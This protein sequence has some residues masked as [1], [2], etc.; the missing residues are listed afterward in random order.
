MTKRALPLVALYLAMAASTRI[1]EPAYFGYIIAFGVFIAGYGTQLL[2]RKNAPPLSGPVLLGWAVFAALVLLTTLLAKPAFRDLFRDCGAI[3]SFL[4]GLVV[5]PRALGKDWERPLFAGLSA[6][7]MVIS[8]WTILGAVAAYLAGAG[9]YEWRGVYVPFAHGWLP[10][11]IVAEYIRSRS[12]ADFRVSAF[13]IGLCVLALL[14]SLSRTGILLV[15][16]FGV[17]ILL[18]NARHWLLSARGMAMVITAAVAAAVVLPQLWQ[19]DVVQQRVQA[20]VGPGDLSL[21]WRAM[22][23][24]AAT[25][26]LSDGGWRRWLFGFGLGARVPLPIGIV[27]F[28][29]NP[30]IP[31]LHNS[32]WT[33]LVKFGAV[34]LT[35][36]LVSIGVLLTRAHLVRGGVPALLTGGTWILL[37]VL[38]TAV[39]LQGMTEWSHLTFLGIACALLG[40]A[41]HEPRWQPAHVAQD[42]TRITGETAGPI[43]ATRVSGRAV[44]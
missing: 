14:L 10:Y 2:T 41:A 35:W 34:G 21:G 28:A 8:V 4:F 39:T 44:R 19:L 25:N 26:Y 32:Y 33:Y 24:T 27:D 6:L 42:R 3:A 17:V 30:T 22:E 15:G 11:L 23:E 13:R 43:P 18:I 40:K 29:G 20:G 12:G 16:T 7:A 36:V 31:H 38:G 1:F 5:I 37:F 9:S